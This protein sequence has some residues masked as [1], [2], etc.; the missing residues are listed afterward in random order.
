L[1]LT[2][3]LLAT[4]HVHR[5][6][7]DRSFHANSRVVLDDGLCALCL[8]HFNCPVSANPPLI[9]AQPALVEASLPATA[10]RRRQSSV[11]ACLFGRAPPST[12]L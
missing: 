1:L 12:A 10:S 11:K 3:Q 6:A 2:A 7:F 8:F 5:F 9:L 4:A